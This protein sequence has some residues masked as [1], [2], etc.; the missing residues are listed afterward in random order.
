MIVEKVRSKFPYQTCFF[1]F[2]CARTL[3]SI[4]RT[5]EWPF[6]LQECHRILKPGG[7]IELQVLDPTPTRSGSIL[8]K[9]LLVG[10]VNGLER[11]FRSSRPGMLTPLWLEEAGFRKV[12]EENVNLPTAVSGSSPAER[13]KMVTG[14]LI[15]RSLYE[16]FFPA[17]GK[18]FGLW[19][20]EDIVAECLEVETSLDLLILRYEKC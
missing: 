4:L 12:Y 5:T 14:R 15:Y 7:I 8:Q 10:L 13:L 18:D 17:L 6:F 20:E 9:R 2:L 11:H 3:P 19:E 16:R 1:D